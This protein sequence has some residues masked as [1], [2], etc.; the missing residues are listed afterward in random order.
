VTVSASDADGPVPP[1]TFDVTVVVHT[2]PPGYRD[3][4]HD[5][6]VSVP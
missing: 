5:N 6:N 3:D 1:V 4:S 2:S